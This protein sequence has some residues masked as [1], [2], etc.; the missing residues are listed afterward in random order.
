MAKEEMKSFVL[1]E[2]EEELNVVSQDDTTLIVLI[3]VI[4]LVSGPVLIWSGHHSTGH[5]AAFR[6]VCGTAMF[7]AGALYFFLREI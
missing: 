2:K 7:I 1:E 6:T 3:A 4:M 5:M